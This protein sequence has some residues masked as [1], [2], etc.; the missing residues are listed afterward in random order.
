M[1]CGGFLKTL[2][3]KGCQEIEDDALR[4]FSQNCKNIEELVLCDCNKI[5]NETCIS[6]SNFAVGLV[7]LDLESCTQ[8]DDLGIARIG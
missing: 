5:T 3:L 4:T 2:N 8:I 7:V 6:L 1:R